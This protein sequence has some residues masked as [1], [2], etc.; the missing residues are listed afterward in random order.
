LVLEQLLFQVLPAPVSPTLLKKSWNIG[1]KRK[2]WSTIFKISKIGT[3]HPNEIK[4]LQIV[5]FSICIPA[6]PLD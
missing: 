3:N 5:R 4:A 2:N 6:V 1:T